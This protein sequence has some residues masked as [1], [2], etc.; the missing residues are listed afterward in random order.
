MSVV[1]LHIFVQR[2][3]I[4]GSEFEEDS[5]PRTPTENP[6]AKTLYNNFHAIEVISVLS[7]N[8]TVMQLEH[9]FLV[10]A[11][12]TGKACTNSHLRVPTNATRGTSATPG[13]FP[14]HNNNAEIRQF[15]VQRD[16]TS[17]FQYL[18]GTTVAEAH[19]QRVRTYTYVEKERFVRKASCTNAEEVDSV[20]QEVCLHR[21]VPVNVKLAI[22]VHQAQRALNR[23]GVRM[24][25]CIAPRKVRCRLR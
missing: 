20:R 9:A 22:F 19:P 12:D 15:I 13:P 3:P 16:R 14:K 7:M 23:I 25:Q 8:T 17:Q 5:L 21:N 4:E 6:R 11:E 24:R 1:R 18:M 10:L 2:T